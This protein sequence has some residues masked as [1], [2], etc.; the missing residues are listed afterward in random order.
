[1]MTPRV[2]TAIIEIIMEYD[3]YPNGTH[4][5]KSLIAP[6]IEELRMELKLGTPALSLEEDE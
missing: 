1:M 5:R 6:M 3:L 4:V 2:R